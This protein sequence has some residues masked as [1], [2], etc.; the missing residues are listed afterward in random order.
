[1][2]AEHAT[3]RP[4]FDVIVRGK[5][6]ALLLAHGAGGGIQGNFGLVLDDLARDHTVIGPHYPGS[7]ATPVATDPIRLDDLADRV[8]AAAVTRG[9]ES[10][11][12]L[13]ESLGAAVAV[14]A[15]TR[16]PERVTALVLTAGFAVAD[17]ALAMA[18][19][20]IKV[21]GA[22]GEWRAL[23][24]LGCVTCMSDTDEAGYS[25]P[26]LDAVIQRFQ[27]QIPP[28][29]LDHFDLVARVDV[30]DDLAR[31]SAPTLVVI[32]TG[33]RLILPD[34]SRRL[35]DGIPGAEAVELPGAGHILG[36]SDRATW[37]RL[38]REFLAGVGPRPDRP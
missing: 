9:H 24:R 38:V 33:D 36:E 17:P 2:S 21:L 35:A 18:T 34:T 31:V 7:G 30:R 20:F 4:D 1:M 22:A 10:F 32:P 6:P 19:Q 3:P 5:G 14:R 13:G 26:E 12:V 25:A 28:G 11:A 37:L 15:A 16:H 8:V 27:E 29:T 23:A